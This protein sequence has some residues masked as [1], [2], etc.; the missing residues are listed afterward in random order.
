MVVI[1]FHKFIPREWRIPFFKDDVLSKRVAI[2]I[3]MF[4][5]MIIL[6]KNFIGSAIH[7]LI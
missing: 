5:F 2:F 7:I 3:F 1:I 6:F 4:F